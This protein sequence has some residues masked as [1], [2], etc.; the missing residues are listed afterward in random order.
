[1][2]PLNNCQLCTHK[3]ELEIHK[4]WTVEQKVEHILC[5]EKNLFPSFNQSLILPTFRMSSI[6]Y[7]CINNVLQDTNLKSF[8]VEA[9]YIHKSAFILHSSGIPDPFSANTANLA[10]VGYFYM[11]NTLQSQKHHKTQKQTKVESRLI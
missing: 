10:W 3:R 7:V 2:S 1:M 4:P 9:Q 5:T 8:W 6:I 11:V